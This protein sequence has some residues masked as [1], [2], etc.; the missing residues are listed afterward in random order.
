MM[1]VTLGKWN[2]TNNLVIFNFEKAL[3]ADA[4]AT[5]AVKGNSRTVTTW[6]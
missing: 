3:C 5:R 1:S 6:G 4:M 2:I